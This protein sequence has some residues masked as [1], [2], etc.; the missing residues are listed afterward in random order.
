ML[1]AACIS[2]PQSH[3]EYMLEHRDT[4]H[5]EEDS[6]DET[7][8]LSVGPVHHHHEENLPQIPWTLGMAEQLRQRMMAYRPS[9]QGHYQEYFFS[10]PLEWQGIQIPQPI[11][12]QSSQAPLLKITV[13]GRAQEL[14]YSQTAE[15]KGWKI[16][17]IFSNQ[18]DEQ[19]QEKHTYLFVMKENQQATILELQ[20]V[21]DGVVQMTSKVASELETILLSLTEAD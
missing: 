9:H 21:Q 15:E 10:K 19:A 5:H 1:L 8:S 13:D 18:A 12:Q 17:A 4:D 11:T 14:L 16:V 3:A 7:E 20:T 6:H 2:R